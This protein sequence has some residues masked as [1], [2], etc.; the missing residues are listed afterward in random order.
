VVGVPS[1]S[2]DGR[3]LA[4]SAEARGNWEIYVVGFDGSGLE[5]LTAG[6]DGL[7]EP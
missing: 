7:R 2:P 6:A 5:R 3:R 1:W 4:F